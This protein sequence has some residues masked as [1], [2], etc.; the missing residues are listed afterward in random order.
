MLGR[1]R[2]LLQS[3]LLAL[4]FALPGVAGAVPWSASYAGLY[5]AGYTPDAPIVV[6]SGGSYSD[7]VDGSISAERL[8]AG[9]YLVHFTGLSA[10][11]ESAG[12]VQ[13]NSQ[14]PSYTCQPVSWGAEDIEVRCW[15]LAGVPD[16]PLYLVAFYFKR[17]SP[18]REMAFAWAD[19]ASNPSYTPNAVYSVNPGGGA[20]L[21][22][23]FG[24]GD[25][26]MTFTGF[27]ATG[28]G[29]GHVQVSAYG[30]DP[31]RCKLSGWS[32]DDV[33]VLC[34]D[35]AGNPADTR[36][37]VIY[38]RPLAH[39]QGLSYTRLDQAPAY[40]G[41]YNPAAS[42][43]YVDGAGPITARH[44]VN[45]G[46]VRIEFDGRTSTLDPAA[47][48]LS[49]AYGTSS[50]WCIPLS[51]DGSK[52]YTYCYQA[53]GTELNWD[54]MRHS[55]LFYR[56][57]PGQFDSQFA[58]AWADEPTTALYEP[59]A[60]ASFIQGNGAPIEISRSGTGVYAVSWPG[61]TATGSDGG[62]IA[63]SA[64]TGG[65]GSAD[66]H[67]EVTNWSDE[68]TAVA[69][70]DASGT[71]A[72]SRFDILYLKPTEGTPGTAYAWAGSPTTASYYANAS[73]A[74]NPAGGNVV[75]TRSGVGTYAVEWQGY[76]PTG[77]NEGTVLVT[78]YQSGGNRCSAVSWG[79][80]GSGTQVHVQCAT[81]AGA[82][83][84]TRFV[85]QMLDSTE[86]ADGFGYA[87]THLSTT[88]SY[89]ASPGY[90]FN[91]MDSDV[92]IDRFGTGD[93]RVTFVDLQAEGH[94]TSRGHAQVVRYGTPGGSCK[95]DDFG[96]A[97]VDVSCLDA[98]GNPEDAKFDVLYVRPTRL[99]EPEAGIGLLAGAMLLW[100][101]DRHRRR[102]GA[103]SPLPA[104][105]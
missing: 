37:S 75:I 76:S 38:F 22:E 12:N 105:P 27:G 53:D 7:A 28:S 35:Y 93:Y 56:P 1:L 65:G 41:S 44:Q 8:S 103:R 31:R 16:D 62:T 80:T 48:P 49:T 81:P 69:C 23:R 61:M 78:P 59:D 10:V 6:L 72:D 45:A 51:S 17:R 54:E 34:F 47:R 20:I 71:P 68:S 19:Q 100:L 83:A 87:W 88:A 29:T 4:V 26:R 25:Y 14:D 96:P 70:F 64:H 39:R 89:L 104:R 60:D 55:T 21:A 66:A 90:S 43:S 86:L 79:A 50:D 67:C 2:W 63:V 30:P 73:Y 52:E 11:E 85:V 57:P 24:V 58:Y 46:T 32:G 102:N 82:A 9:H 5:Y 42:I 36:Y 101:L 92:Q 84:D 97:F 33:D 94:L 3:V 95:L 74:H 77:T 98:S 13:V 18:T 91:S 99:P 15:D 40:G